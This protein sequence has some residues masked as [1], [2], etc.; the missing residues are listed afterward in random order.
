M[1]I[2]KNWKPLNFGKISSEFQ[3]VVCGLG[4]D[5]ICFAT[6]L[7]NTR[8]FTDLDVGYDKRKILKSN[9]N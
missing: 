9:G 3:E 5:A 1:L 6:W 4:P 8:E 2:L 7:D